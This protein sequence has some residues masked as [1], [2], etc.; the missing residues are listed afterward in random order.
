[1]AAPAAAPP[2]RAPVLVLVSLPP[3]LSSVSRCTARFVRRPRFTPK[4]FTPPPMPLAVSTGSVTAFTTPV[5]TFTSDSP[6]ERANTP[7]FDSSSS[8]RIAAISW[9][10]TSTC[11]R[12]TASKVPNGE[13][14]VKTCQV[15]GVRTAGSIV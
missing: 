7:A 14:I 10:R 9:S 12:P 3:G 13:V 4:R 6:A 1:M 2:T 5:P 8:R 15:S 11:A